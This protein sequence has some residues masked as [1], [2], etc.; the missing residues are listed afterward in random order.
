MIRRKWT[1]LFVAVSLLFSLLAML[2]V[3]AGATEAT[4]E[5]AA[6]IQN[7]GRK[8]AV[9]VYSM[10]GTTLYSYKPD[11]I[12]SG[13]SLIKLPYCYYACTQLENGVHS[14]D[15]T[16]TYTKS[17]YHGGSG[18]IRHNGYNVDYTIEQLIDYALRY[19]D[20]VAYDMLFSLFGINGFNA[21]V[22]SWGYDIHVAD[23]SPHFPGVTANFMCE[24]MRRMQERSRDGGI[25][26]TA[27]TA[28]C[29][30]TAT[31]VRPVLGNAATPVAVKYGNISTVWHEACYV[32]CEHPYILIILSSATSM[33]PD[34]TFLQNVAACSK[35]INEEHVLAH[36]LDALDESLVTLGDVNG[37]GEINSVDAVFIMKASA[38]IG[39]GTASGFSEVQ[40]AAADLNA[41]TLT[42]AVDATLLLQ[43]AAYC[44]A[45][46]EMML[47]EYLDSYDA[48]PTEET[49]P[50]EATT[51][52]ASVDATEETEPVEA[53]TETASVDATEETEPVEATTE[54]ASTEASE[55]TA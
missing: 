9:V 48:E 52:T 2:P 19:S 6:L 43:F 30:S 20:N 38:N 12:M 35:K 49:E 28:L 45:G 54:T 16:V 26:E 5:M 29:E 25:W 27:W 41:D 55:K 32:D 11:S 17:W 15:E 40:T 50:V 51:E 37:D 36:E 3:R 47:P 22:D 31:Y 14:V 24:S 21:M 7:Y 46:G 53:T 8:C 33:Q 23:P 44:G 13:A 39:A 42:D 4:D 34:V 18:I 1:S 10:D